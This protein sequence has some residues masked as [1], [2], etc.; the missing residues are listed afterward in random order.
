MLSSAAWQD[1]ELA[2]RL[3]AD[4]P[5]TTEGD[6]Q[7]QELARRLFNGGNGLH[8][9]DRLFGQVPERLRQP[10][11]E[12]AFNC[13]SADSLGDPQRW[14]GRLSLL[15]EASRAKGVESIARAWA[16][17]TPGRPLARA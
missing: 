3:V 10:L 16:M 14:I 6:A 9:F 5:R 17:Q 1:P 4:L 13:L 12:E 2:L 11:V 15:P 7:V 8:R